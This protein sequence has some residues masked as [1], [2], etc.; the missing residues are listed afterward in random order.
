[1][2]RESWRRC[3]GEDTMRVGAGFTAGARHTNLATGFDADAPA[4][5]KA[6]AAAAVTTA[7]AA[8]HFSSGRIHLLT[9]GRQWHCLQERVVLINIPINTPIHVKFGTSSAS[10]TQV[11]PPAQNRPSLQPGVPGPSQ[12]S[13]T[14]RGFMHLRSTEL[15]VSPILQRGSPFGSGLHS[16]PSP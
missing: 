10:L 15:Q 5:N 8:L 12:S 4:A 6:T 7:E 14:A 11:S 16:F 9:L 1:L 13:P 2:A 3:R